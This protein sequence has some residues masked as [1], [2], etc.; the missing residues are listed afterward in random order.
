MA[1][2]QAFQISGLD[3]VLER[4]QALPKEVVQKNGGPV[5]KVL[6]NAA[7]IIRDEAKANVRKIIAT[8]NIDGQNVSTGT[9]EKSIRTVK[10]RAHRTLVDAHSG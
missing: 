2:N 3:G 5:R 9:L 1:D 7:H 10:G 8:P 4:L 6:R